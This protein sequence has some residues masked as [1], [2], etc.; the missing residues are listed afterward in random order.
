MMS[1]EVARE[2][3]SGEERRGGVGFV[4]E[5]EQQEIRNWVAFSQTRQCSSK[6]SQFS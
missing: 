1:V 2:E 6:S 5:I 4:E 3:R